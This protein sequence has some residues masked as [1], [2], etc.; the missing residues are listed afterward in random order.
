MLGSARQSWTHLGC[1]WLLLITV[2]AHAVIPTGSPLARSQGSAFSISTTD[3]SLAPK[4]RAEA[5][6]APGPAAPDDALAGPHG[7]SGEAAVAASVAALPPSR[8]S[9]GVRPAAPADA[10]RPALA[11]ANRARAPPAG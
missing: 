9:S 4:R 7:P 11:Q 1:L 10:A 2:F 6:G 8:R 3:V 5:K